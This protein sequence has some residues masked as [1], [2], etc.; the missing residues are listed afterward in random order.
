[1]PDTLGPPQPP[2]EPPTYLHLGDEA[3]RRRTTVWAALDAFLDV[4]LPVFTDLRRTVRT[5]RGSLLACGVVQLHRD[6]LEEMRRKRA[7]ILIARVVLDGEVWPFSDMAAWTDGDGEQ[8]VDDSVGE[9]S[10]EVT[11]G[12]LFVGTEDAD[13]VLPEVQP[14]EV[15]VEGAAERP[16]EVMRLSEAI[17]ELPWRDGRARSF[18]YAA[19]IVIPT[20][21]KRGGG[22]VLKEDLHAALRAL[23]DDPEPPPPPSPTN[24]SSSLPARRRRRGR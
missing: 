7:P 2:P 10:L 18:I 19:G 3:P 23:R 13:R 8:H 21:D 4:G 16:R 11:V 14:P 20:G 5:L 15:R 24:G 6:D 9:D 17:A 12:S 22:I 1:M